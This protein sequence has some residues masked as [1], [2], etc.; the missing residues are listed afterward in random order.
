VK[1][2]LIVLVADDDPNDLQLLRQAVQRNGVIVNL[3]E[4]RDGDEVLQYLR[5]ENG[6]KDR[7]KHPIPDL[8]ILDLKMPSMDGLQVLDWLRQQPECSRM[9]TVMLSGSGLE[10]DV[11]EAY[12]RGVNTYFAK[13]NDFKDLER[14]IKLVVDYWGMS[15]R[16]AS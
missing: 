8:I 11:R 14:L 1:R 7:K 2:K 3:H 13:P 12:R 6:F 15:E 5:G 9:P 10:K 4:V 16:V